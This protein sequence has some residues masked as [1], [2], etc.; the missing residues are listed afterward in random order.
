MIPKLEFMGIL[1][2]RNEGYFLL[3]FLEEVSSFGNAV[4][5]DQTLH[6]MSLIKADAP[7]KSPT[8]TKP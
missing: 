7:E 3:P 1:P 5:R 4:Y 8:E 6:S 2:L